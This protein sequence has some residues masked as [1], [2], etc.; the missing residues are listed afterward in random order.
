M[1]LHHSGGSA[2][3]AR[4]E[5]EGRQSQRPL[6]DDDQDHRRAG[7]DRAPQAARDRRGLRLAP[8]QVG[9]C[10]THALES[11]VIAGFVHGLSVGDVEATLADALGS[12]AALS[13]PTISRV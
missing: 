4:G 10:R 3:T 9:A 6:P 13:E 12:E 8:A 1:I 5:G 11:L 2:L 7:H